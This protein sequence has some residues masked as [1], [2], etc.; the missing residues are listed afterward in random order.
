[1]NDS[2][3]T[4]PEGKDVSELLAYVEGD[5]EE[6]SRRRLEEHLMSCAA[7]SG[8]VASLRM[9]DGLLQDHPESL[10][11]LEEEICRFVQ[12]GE[13]QFGDIAAHLQWCEDCR[14]DAEM[15]REM[16]SEGQEANVAGA[17]MPYALMRRLDELHERGTRFG[18]IHWLVSSCRDYF[19]QPFRLPMLALGTG[20]AVLIIAIVGKPLWY[21]YKEVQAPSLRVPVQRPL[22]QREALE[23]KPKEE[24]SVADE[25]TARKPQAPKDEVEQ[26][27]PGVSKPAVVSTRPSGVLEQPA[28]KPLSGDLDDSKAVGTTKEHE[29]LPSPQRRS[30]IAKFSNQ[31]AKPRTP[32]KGPLKEESKPDASV[33][34]EGVIPHGASSPLASALKGPVTVRIIDSDGRPIQG[35]KFEPPP[36]LRDRLRF[37][38]VG[39]GKQEPLSRRWRSERN[40]EFR[41]S[42]DE[43]KIQ[44]AE[45]QDAS[46][47]LVLVRLSKSQGVYHIRATFFEQGMNQ[48]VSKTVEAFGIDPKDLEKRI[49]YIVSAMLRKP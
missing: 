12:S 14:E 39:K 1:M 18:F 11:P 21:S 34:E 20:A 26:S 47:P 3:F 29:A 42:P 44:D 15:V 9:M 36:D 7:C 16:L 30:K 25:F 35:L 41:S 28:D 48:G 38:D 45:K 10:H 22:S 17:S 33:A 24:E 6:S 32:R 2:E 19:A 31:L 27:E 40:M 5:M 23:M 43:G 8:E 46:G 4:C 13:D 49:A 37:L